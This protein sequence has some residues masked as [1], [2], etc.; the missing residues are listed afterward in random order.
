MSAVIIDDACPRGEFMA[1]VSARVRRAAIDWPP[2]PRPLQTYT[3]GPVLEAFLAALRDG[4]VLELRQI[5]GHP[6]V[7]EVECPEGEHV[8]AFLQ[9]AGGGR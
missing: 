3:H 8:P 6:V 2:Q 7:L 5:D 9:L 1:N 4:R